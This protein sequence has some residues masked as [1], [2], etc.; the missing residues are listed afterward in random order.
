MWLVVIKSHSAS[1]IRKGIRLGRLLFLLLNRP[2]IR[3]FF[4]I[5]IT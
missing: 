4:M 2:A 3:G 1:N 5:E